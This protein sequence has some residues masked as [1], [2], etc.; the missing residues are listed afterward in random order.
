MWMGGLQREAGSH[1]FPPPWESC[2]ED[3][4][5][6]SR[7]AEFGELQRKGVTALLKLVLEISDTQADIVS[8]LSC[9]LLLAAES[10]LIVR[11]GQI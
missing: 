7:R 5:D 4:V 1:F 2:P 11:T 10:I 3:K 9:F 6:K 8:L